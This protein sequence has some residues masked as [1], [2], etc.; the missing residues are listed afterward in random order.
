MKFRTLTVLTVAAIVAAASLTAC[1]GYNGGAGNAPNHVSSRDLSGL[2]LGWQERLYR[3]SAEVPSSLVGKQLGTAAYHG[4]VGLAFKVYRL[5]LIPTS[6]AVVFQVIGGGPYWK[7]QV[8]T[9]P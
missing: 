6:K 1:A 4:N 9:S 3:L 2:V 5:R 8:T 7:A